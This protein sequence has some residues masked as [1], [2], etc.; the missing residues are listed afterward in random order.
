METLSGEKIAVIEYIDAAELWE[1]VLGSGALEWGDWF[2]DGVLFHD[3][4][5]WQNPGRVTIFYQDANDPECD[6]FLRKTLTVADLAS[7]LGVVREQGYCRQPVD[8]LDA[9]A[10]D[11]VLQQAIYGRQVFG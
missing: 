10:G 5:D 7:A 6:P 2:H 1:C 8:T 3:N 4:A 9:L 11:T